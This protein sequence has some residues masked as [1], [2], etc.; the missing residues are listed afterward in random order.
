MSTRVND[1]RSILV[2]DARQVAQADGSA[3]IEAEHVLLALAALEHT[4]ITS[5]LAE[6]GLTPLL[7]Q[8]ALDQEWEQGLAVAGVRIDVAT[9]PRPTPDPDR[10]PRIGESTVQVLKRATACSS[11]LGGGR[12]GVGHILIGLLDADRSRVA[13]ALDAAGVDR[14]ALRTK[15]FDLLAQ[16]N[17]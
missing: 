10:R 4:E 17:R 9:L 6:A 5:L 11:A 8:R 3:T 2:R 15:A 7:L 13:R 1:V 12:I 14:V 16:G